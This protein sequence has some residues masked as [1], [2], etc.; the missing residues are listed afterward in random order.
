MSIISIFENYGFRARADHSLE[1]G[2]GSLVWGHYATV[3]AVG[4]DLY[5][6]RYRVW[7]YNEDMDPVLEE[8]T[9]VVL[10]GALALGYLFER[11]PLFR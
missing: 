4:P 3:K 9:E 8:N 11:L 10:H 1:W 2:V 7:W 6:V 5:K